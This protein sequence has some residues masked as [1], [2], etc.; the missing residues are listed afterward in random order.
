MSTAIELSELPAIEYPES[1]RLSLADN[2]S[3]L[4]W[5]FTIFGGVGN[6]GSVG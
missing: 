5:M 4:W 3:Q 2:T 6:A 1:D